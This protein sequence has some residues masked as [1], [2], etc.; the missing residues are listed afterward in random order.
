MAPKN[1]LLTRHF[2]NAEHSAHATISARL[3]IWTRLSTNRSPDIDQQQETA[4]SLLQHRKQHNMCH[5]RLLT[6]LSSLFSFPCAVRSTEIESMGYFAQSMGYVAQCRGYVA[7]SMG[8]VAQCRVYV[9]QCRGYV[10]QCRS[11]VAQNMGYVAQTFIIIIIIII[12]I[13]IIT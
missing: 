6:S 1:R 13:T 8:Y 11:Y 10:A 7:Q 5:S 2:R 4:V 12:I 9:A 3:H